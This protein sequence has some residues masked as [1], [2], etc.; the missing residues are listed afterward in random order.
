M[1]NLEISNG[2]L[3]LMVKL[4]LLEAVFQSHHTPHQPTFCLDDTSDGSSK[5]LVMNGKY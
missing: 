4:R 2:L 1:F 3:A 5:Y